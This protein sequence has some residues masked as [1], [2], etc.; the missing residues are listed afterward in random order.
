M[1]VRMF[2]KVLPLVVTLGLNAIAGAA[3]Q[4]PPQSQSQAGRASTFV[5][6]EGSI[7]TIHDALA[8]KDV[9]CVQVVQAYLRR[10][11]T[12]D[13]RGPALNA[14]ISINPA[15]LETAAELDRVS[16]RAP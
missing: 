11:E 10:I 7:S 15:A 12:Y 13:D 6:D 9:T 14:I 3:D 4:P 16:S 2:T 8:S 5:P 1:Q